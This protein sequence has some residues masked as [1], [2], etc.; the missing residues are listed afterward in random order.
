MDILAFVGVMSSTPV[1]T[2]SAG[3]TVVAPNG[4]IRAEMETRKMIHD[5]IRGLKTEY[6][7]PD[8][9]RWRVSRGPYFSTSTSADVSLATSAS[10]LSSVA[11][12]D[13][14]SLMVVA[15]HERQSGHTPVRK[16]W[17]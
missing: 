12:V 7:G 5:F 6:G 15:A 3:S 4:E 14:D 13:L 16:G 9:C 1:N 17:S 10:F 2:L 8:T 11:D